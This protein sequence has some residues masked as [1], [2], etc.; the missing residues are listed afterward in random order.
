LN[1]D[2]LKGNMAQTIHR[3]KYILAEPDL[4]LENAA[5]RVSG[6]GQISEIE[7]LRGRSPSAGSRVFDWGTAVILPGLVNAHTH[8]EL[9]HL[10]N[11]LLQFDS[12]TDWISQLINQRR[13]WT[14]E[15]F[16]SSASE[17]F[18]LSLASG[19]TLVGDITSSGIGSDA[20]RDEGPRRVV[21]EETVAFLPA[22]AGDALAKLRLRFAGANPDVT[23][24]QGVSPHAP[25]SV[26]P[27]LYKRAAEFARHKGML[28]ATH[29]AETREEI[30][31]LLEG[32]GDFRDFLGSRDLLPPDWKPPGLPP[33]LYLDSLGVLGPF[34]SLIHCNYLDEE[35]MERI[36]RTGCSVVYCPRSHGFFGHANHPVRKLLDLGI[37]VALGT[38]S[39]AS[40]S[41]LS[42]IDEMRFLFKA[43]KDIKPEE[44]LRL[45]TVNGASALCPGGSLGRLGCGYLADIT[46]VEIP[47][48][49][50]AQQLLSKIM[51]GAGE[52]TATIVNGKV[53]WQRQ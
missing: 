36:L 31:L 33:V 46:I 17:G 7:S 41:S 52:C 16:L 11:R 21:F 4:L 32:T 48:N 40:N 34:C 8:L 14:Q 10:Q 20:M 3:A 27:E 9:T 44:I 6:N 38:D 26:S 24:M 53:A 51:E 22:Q 43:R 1:T 42:M 18:R 25:Y 49:L 39:L 23:L 47:E 15:K 28:L 37:N 2:I 5:V 50:G 45:A 12:F 13:P 29:A 19:T 35:S 30:Q